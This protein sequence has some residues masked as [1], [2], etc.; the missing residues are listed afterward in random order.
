[1]V[2][3][4]AGRRR[5]SDGSVG[6]VEGG[7][8][9][10]SPGALR[11]VREICGKRP[12]SEA[13][14]AY[15]SYSA[16]WEGAR[17]AHRDAAA[18]NHVLCRRPNQGKKSRQAPGLHVYE[19]QSTTS[20]AKHGSSPGTSGN[21]ARRYALHLKPDEGAV[22]DDQRIRCRPTEASPIVLVPGPDHDDPLARSQ[23]LRERMRLIQHESR[24]QGTQ[25]FV[26]VAA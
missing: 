7:A 19:A 16:I 22:R 2:Q 26:L 13:L 25:Q 10:A 20:S 23:T 9:L 12:D 11:R 5:D 8:T 21:A 1:M 17:A 18:P 14:S 3:R 24:P 6:G 15:Y 4:P